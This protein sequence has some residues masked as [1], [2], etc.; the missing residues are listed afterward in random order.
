MHNNPN[1]INIFSGT[2]EVAT[3]G[4]IKEENLNTAITM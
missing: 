1:E 2:A 3:L 4:F